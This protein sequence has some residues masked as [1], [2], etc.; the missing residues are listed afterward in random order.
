VRFYIPILV[1]LIVTACAKKGSPDG[2]PKDEN[3]PILVTAKPPYETTNFKAKRIRFYFDEYIVLK[4]V[5]TKLIVSPPLKNAPIISPQGTASKY[6]DIQILD[7]LQPNTTYTFNFGDAIQDNNENN[8][9]ENFKYVFSTGDYIDSLTTKG[10]VTSALYGKLKKNVNIVLFELDSTYNDSIFYKQKPKYVTNTIDSVNFE[11]TNLKQGKYVMMAIDEESTDYIFNPKTDK[12][13][14]LDNTITLPNDTIVST[15]ISIFKETQPYKFKR[16]KEVSKGK[17]LFGYEGKQENIKASLT[18]NVPDNFKSFSLLENG[19]DTLNYWHNAI[20]EGIDS[21]NFIVSNKEFLDTITVKLRKK[22]ID[23]LKVSTTTKGTLHLLDTM[24]LTTNNPITTIDKTKFTL[25]NTQDSVAVNYELKQQEINKLAILFE[26]KPKTNYELSVLPKGIIDLYEVTNDSLNYK[27][28]T[29]DPED[30]GS[31]SLTIEKETKSSIIIQ[32]LQNNK[33]F[34][35]KHIPRTVRNVKFNLL[36]PK[37]Y[38]IRAII[39]KNENGVWDTGNFLKK[40]H[41]EKIIQYPNKIELRANWEI[42]EK[43]IIK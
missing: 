34:K 16:G 5:N 7:T 24:F 33:V 22:E 30:Y 1:L 11:F 43:F 38:T 41:P 42:N 28:N 17:I 39:D 29:K 13:G 12:I 3:A 19:K 4:D 40:I 35:T 8:K 21:L 20:E 14:F 27:F 26:K 18:S 37:E 15:P 23:S 9:V 2:G 31:I 10:T 6:V 25:T 36:E 32:L